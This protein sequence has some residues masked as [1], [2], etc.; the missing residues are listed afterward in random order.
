M[1]IDRTGDRIP[2][3]LLSFLPVFI[4]LEALSSPLSPVLGPVTALC[5]HYSTA[6]HSVQCSQAAMGEDT[7]DNLCFVC[8]GPGLPCP[9]CGLV[10]ACSLH[11]A[12]H[13][14]DTQC[15]PFTI[16]HTPAQGHFMVATRD[17]KQMELIL[18]EAPVVVG[19]YTRSPAPQLHCVECFKQLDAATCATCPLCGY[20]VCGDTCRGGPAH[21]AE[22]AVFVRAGW[23]FSGNMEDLAAI[24][25]I[26]L[27][28]L[29]NR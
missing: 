2:P 20:P 28:E 25:V 15:W 14:P 27:L 21:A 11:L 6:Q 12:I 16:R 23:R 5:A 26:R 17:I 13:R 8:G 1:I 19:P 29:K 22:C 3:L 7:E 24:T 9:H 10:T 4:I 18:R